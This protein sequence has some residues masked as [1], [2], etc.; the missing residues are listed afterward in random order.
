M[1]IALVDER[2][3]DLSVIDM[4]LV[5]RHS[6]LHQRQRVSGDL[7]TQSTR[8]TVDHHAHLIATGRT[9]IWSRT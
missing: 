9:T 7:M 1:V 3:P 5:S 4:N 6:L 2:T 8:A